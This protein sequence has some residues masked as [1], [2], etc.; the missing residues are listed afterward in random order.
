MFLIPMFIQSLCTRS[1]QPSKGIIAS[2]KRFKAKKQDMLRFADDI[3]VLVECEED[4]K[5]ILMIM[6]IIFKNEYNMKIKKSKIKILAR[7]RNEVVKPY[8]ILDG[9]TLK[10]VDECKYLGSMINNYGGCAQEIR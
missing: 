2:R 1:H 10:T 9:N 4:L 8:I 3:V 6:N 7:G 5:N